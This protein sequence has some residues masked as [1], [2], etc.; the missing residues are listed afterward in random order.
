MSQS[1]LSTL[2]LLILHE[3][4]DLAEQ[5]I[6]SLRNAG[7]ATRAHHINKNE[8]FVELLQS[9]VWDLLI[10]RPQTDFLSANDAL[11]NIQKLEK[12]IPVL[13]LLD[14]EDLDNING[15]LQA[16][17]E[18]AIPQ[19]DALRLQLVVARELRNLINR[20]A[21]R[22]SVRAIRETEKRSSQLLEHSK[23]AIAYL[24]DGMHVYANQAYIELFGFSDPEDIEITPVMDL[25]AKSYKDSFKEFI[26]EQVSEEIRELKLKGSK[27]DGEEFEATFVFAKAEYDGEPCTQIKIPASNEDPALKEQLETYKKQDLVTGL[28]N[29]SVFQTKLDEAVE[30]AAKENSTYA[31]FYIKLDFF[32]K[33]KSTIG[34]VDSDVLLG[35]V[36]AKLSSFF[37]QPDFI[38]RFGEDT[39]TAI[40]YGKGLEDAKTYAETIRKQI[41]ERLF[42]VAERTVQITCSIG[43]AFI[44]DVTTDGDVILN[45]A[46]EACN[47]SYE[48]NG[49]GNSIHA[50]EPVVAKTAKNINVSQLLQEAMDGGRLKV[51]FQPIINLQEGTEESYEVFMRLLDENRKEI[52]L[53]DYLEGM[54]STEIGE[55]V[56]RWIILQAIKAL[57]EHRGKGHNTKLFMNI[58]ERSL[59]DKSLLPWL[60]VALKA[61]R[62][63]GNAIIFQI[64]ETDAISYLKQTIAFAASLAELK[65]RLAI[66]QFGC[67]LNPFNIMN[68]MN[69]D[70]IKIDQ[71]FVQDL[72]N[73]ENQEAIA[74][75]IKG[76]H[77]HK[78]QIIIP[79]IENAQML[80]TIWQMG[81]DYIQ[82]YY[83]QEPGETMN[84]DFSSDE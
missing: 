39:F 34:V 70:F 26:K 29:Q 33:T 3:S 23:D 46:Y 68:H 17:A 31:L 1:S 16:G 8:D 66:K 13:V 2:H 10:A 18:D 78:K 38:A 11:L 21:M 57:A 19:S 51:L 73:K 14:D 12:D 76:I 6:N 61:A 67:A 22:D 83:F 43:I 82:G 62:L 48:N 27:Q 41:A 79:F 50:H 53:R 75:F 4:T 7:H 20:R 59:L 42:E 47:L 63:P 32:N 58:T 74:A 77:E 9:K 36:A 52:S 64:A 49:T 25:I 54:S 24:I 65:C 30:K 69:V 35:E 45:K 44:N 15:Y 81:A 37:T 28:P 40:D 71:S 55:K 72:S 84:Y 5:L 60:G 80:S 56:D